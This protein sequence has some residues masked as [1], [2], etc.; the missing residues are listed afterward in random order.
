[1]AFEL[2]LQKSF[3][4]FTTGSDRIPV[5]GMSEMSFKI[6]RVNNTEMLVAVL[7]QILFIFI[8]DLLLFRLPMAHT[9][10]NQLMLPPYKSESQLKEKL[11]I[12]INNSEGFGIE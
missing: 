10:F 11:L 2:Q 12:A 4:L 6:T 3:L 7:S 1:M 9:C 8:G 5:G